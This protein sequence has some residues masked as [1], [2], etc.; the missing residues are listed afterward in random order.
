MD[1][2]EHERL[3]DERTGITHHFSICT[4]DKHG[5]L[6]DVDGY[7]STGEYKDGRLGEV[8]V[9]VGKAGDA[10]ALLDAWALA[11]S[12]NLQHGAKL[13]PLMEKFVHMQFEPSGS[14]NNADIPRTSSPVDY[15]S[16]WL[17]RKYGEGKQ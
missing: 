10:T 9:K 3:P 4:V 5:K 7:I 12:W 17:L 14:T 2:G 1:R 16:R 11:V 15:C 8:F 6:A 13:E